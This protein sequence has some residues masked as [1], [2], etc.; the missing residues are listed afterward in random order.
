MDKLRDLYSTLITNDKTDKEK[1]EIKT[2][3]RWIKNLISQMRNYAE[4]VSENN[5]LKLSERLARSI[6]REVKR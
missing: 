1:I 2:I 3:W 5:R 4:I 6:E